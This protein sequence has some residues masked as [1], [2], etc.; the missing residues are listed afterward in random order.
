M[1]KK[2]I[3][4]TYGHAR[5]PQSWGMFGEI[6]KRLLDNPEYEVYLLD[7]NGNFPGYCWY[8]TC[9]KIGYC[10]KCLKPC[11]KIAQMTGLK[12]ENILKIKKLNIPQIPKFSFL[13][14]ALHYDY[15]GYN[16]GLSPVSSIMTITRDYD[17]SLKKWG[18]HLAKIFKIECIILENIFKYNK[19][20]H[21]DEIHCFTGRTPITYP[22]VSF[23]ETNKIPYVTYEVGANINK[24]GIYNNTVVHDFDNLKKDIKTLWNEAGDD[25]N[26]LA[27]EWFHN[28]RVGKFQAIESF[29]KDQVKNLLPENF[30]FNKQNIVF[31]N[32]S[33]D[34][35]YAFDCWK[36]PFAKTEN[37]LL[38]NLFEHYK[39]DS[40][41]HF[42]LRIHPNLTISKKNN[43]T[44]IREIR[45]FKDKFKNLTIIE[46]DEKIDTYALMDSC[47]KVVTTY[48]TT[49][50]E[51]TYWGKV[52]I[53]AGKAPYEDLDCAYQAKS[54]DELYALIDNPNLKPKPKENTYPYA[55]YNETFGEDYKYYKAK[56]PHE[57]NFMGLELI[58]KRKLRKQNAK[59]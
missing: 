33:I 21:F 12:K 5:A 29:T 26:Q 7:C 53:F 6:L 28:R 27:E 24:L 52:S 46:P 20:F 34:E 8:G 35:I 41:K 2:N 50:F 31:F 54:Y 17:Y 43:T 45:K 11:H 1:V 14:E 9:S 23:A 10:S 40:D 15:K 49:G 51:A 57:G 25:R 37:E 58:D 22:L 42:Y 55:Y 18:K 44:Q 56:S 47:D 13:D 19:E 39:D 4:F 3:L 59:K 32:S 30:D 16:I 36:H 38:E 48:S